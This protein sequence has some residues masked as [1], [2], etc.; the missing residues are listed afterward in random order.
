MFVKTDAIKARRRRTP[1][2]PLAPLPEPVGC[3]SN[4]R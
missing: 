1:L 4:T 2:T 3:G